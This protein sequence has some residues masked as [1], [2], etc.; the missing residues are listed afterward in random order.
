MK[1]YN[2]PSDEVFRGIMKDHKMVPSDAARREFLRDALE[3]PPAKKSGRTGRLLLPGLVLL[4]GLGIV[5][6]YVTREVP[7]ASSGAK[8]A[9]Q[10]VS[11]ATSQAMAAGI[12]KTED[13]PGGK[14]VS[15]PALKT[16]PAGSG[17][18]SATKEHTSPVPLIKNMQTTGETTIL[19]AVRASVPPGFNP[20]SNIEVL[21][22]HA[23]G[24]P[25]Y[26]SAVN[27]PSA[28]GTAEIAINQDKKP[29]TGG[30]TTKI[31]NI[32]LPPSVAETSPGKQA[33]DSLVTGAAGVV[34]KSPS[35]QI[36]NRR[37]N[38]SVGISY[39]PEMLLNTIEGSKFV[40]N[41]SIEGEFRFGK[42]SI[43]TGAGFSFHRG[44][45][46]LSVAYTDYLGSYNKLDSMKFTWNGSVQ[47][48]IPTIYLTDTKL[49]D[50]LQKVESLKVLKRYT[51]LQIPMIMG[52]NFL[53][54]DAFSLGI[55]V[56][57]VMSVMLTSRQISAAFDPGTKRIIS[58]NDIAPEQVS[59]NWQ[60][61]AGVN[62]D[63][64]L[65]KEFRF[66][67]EPWVKYYFNSVYE[68]P[69]PAM[70]PV[71]IGIRGALML[72]L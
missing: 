12:L 62:M 31:S 25:Q 2:H 23:A 72:D 57:P 61:M 44:T 7:A 68:K 70:K 55:R 15:T 56:G 60:A 9:G 22:G 58:I 10:Q 37:M 24:I 67:L 38:P 63:I 20:A 43:R 29:L 49:W 8:K 51:Y 54:T 50:S 36:R 32:Y 45:N 71:S 6:W 26:S 64:R 5:L 14:T 27:V 13:H 41:F 40:Q 69:S 4:A 46:E 19:K 30:D 59:L 17:G 66:E 35:R 47:K 52:Y 21:P 42:F 33:H 28:P 48:Y 18:L 65:S 3:I 34:E 1:K 39:S 11:V 16:P 53:Q